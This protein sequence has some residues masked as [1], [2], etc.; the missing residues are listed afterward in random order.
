MDIAR[1]I[2]AIAKSVLASSSEKE[3]ERLMRAI[4]PGTP[5]AGKT[6]GVGGYV[7]DEALGIDAK[8]LDVVVEMRNG[9]EKITAFLH[10]MFP[11]ETTSPHRLGAGYPIWQI[12]F[13]EDIE[14][15]GE[16]YATQ[17][18][19][20]EFADTQKEMFPDQNSR[21]R[22]VEYGT[23]REDIDR[24][25]FTVNSLLKD[26]TTGEIVDL[27]GSSLQDIKNGVLRGN[28]GVDFDKIL[29]DDPL[30]MI[31]CI[32]FQAKYGWSVPLS[33]LK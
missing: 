5:F 21:Q 6:H 20:I 7:R 19:V 14:H 33:V 12:T 17:G 29:R 1:H 27:T 25:D 26:L 16:T 3:V 18:A 4:L 24:R 28:P 2:L 23:L 31:R 11:V 15:E 13:K 30:R 9:A 10:Q 22:V 32:R 8:D